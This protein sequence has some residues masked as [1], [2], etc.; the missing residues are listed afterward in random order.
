[1]F[2]IGGFVWPPSGT[3]FVVSKTMSTSEGELE[4]KLVGDDHNDDDF[5]IASSDGD[6]EGILLTDLLDQ[7]LKEEKTSKSDVT[8]RAKALAN[9]G[10]KPR[11][12]EN[13]DA[14]LYSESEAEDDDEDGDALN[15]VVHA[16]TGRDLSEQASK[17]A[18]LN[19]EQGV[20]MEDAFAASA[21]NERSGKEMMDKMLS[22]L[23]GNESDDEED[24]VKN[25]GGLKK[26]IARLESGGRKAL[27][28]P[29]PDIVAGRLERAEAY[30]KTKQEVT[31]KWADVVQ[32]NRQTRTLKFPLNGPPKL[33]SNT[34]NAVKTFKPTNNFEQE[35]DSLLKEGGVLGE[36]DVMKRENEDLQQANI[37]KEEI[38]ERRRELARMRS[39]VF[40]N[41]RK[42]KRIKKIKSKKFRKI[43]K[44]E[45]MKVQDENVDDDSDLEGI[46]DNK[47]KAERRRAEERMSLRH[48]NTSKWVRRQLKRGET[49]RNPDARAAIEEQLRTHEQLKRRQE[50]VMELSGSEKGE[51]DRDIDEIGS[52]VEALD[53]E[54]VIMEEG[55]VAAGNEEKKKAKLSLTNMKFM[56]AAA[57]RERKE[58]LS[59]LKE[60]GSDEEGMD[61]YGS[62]TPKI[63]GR[64]KFSGALDDAAHDEEGESEDEEQTRTN[65]MNDTAAQ[66]AG[67]QS[68]TITD[69]VERILDEGNDVRGGF[70]TKL[71]GKISAK[72]KPGSN[73]VKVGKSAGPQPLLSGPVGG[74]K[75]SRSNRNRRKRKRL[76][77]SLN[78]EEDTAAVDA[79]PRDV[80]VSPKVSVTAAKH[81]ELAGAKITGEDGVEKEAPVSAKKKQLEADRA[82]MELVARAFAGLGGA[83]E[84]D[85]E[86]SKQAEIE[87]DISAETKNA[88]TVLPGWGTWDGAGARKR[89]KKSAFAEAAERKLAEAKE[90][91][92]QARGDV[93]TD[94]LMLSMKR[95]KDTRALTIG[96]VPF[97]FRSPR[98]WQR[99]L[100][101]PVLHEL[102]ATKSYTR[103][104]MEKVITKKGV[105]IAPIKHD[106]RRGSG[107]MKGEK[108]KEGRGKKDV[109]E[110][111]KRSA[112]TRD[113]GRRGLLS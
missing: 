56:K 102:S 39:L 20:G 79:A 68:A 65:Y 6:G 9:R 61:E 3:A 16:A 28:A 92:I 62:D 8:E 90:K 93:Y 105:A 4:P 91:A 10:E 104:I 14:L 15:N 106:G 17:K 98:E 46:M 67:G 26:R 71:E 22:V 45:K 75:G 24:G 48:K 33:E 37:S 60:M 23:E 77:A 73:K 94:H 11:E 1:M 44:H 18:A 76:G 108:R 101:T 80:I 7:Q 31:E 66:G 32:K 13:L 59:L 82:R 74:V 53:N 51:S 63:S 100:E 54:L 27:D 109:L 42:M 70:V 25:L 64:M 78:T 99:E 88:P 95:S 50:G 57:E 86:A 40:E 34:A 30:K 112:K 72:T 41:E 81:N 36:K 2:S 97:P 5:E 103:N 55:L 113:R 49:K 111:R 47:I 87:K 96:S 12:D 89:R 38:I 69:D 29:V 43:M 107:V 58:A 84:A 19:V 52:D 35:I 21:S 85:F 83:D 110:R